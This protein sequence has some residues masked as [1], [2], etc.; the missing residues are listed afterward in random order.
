MRNVL[1]I[2]AAVALFGFISSSYAEEQP[3]T[4]SARVAI[5]A[6]YEVFEDAYYRGDAETIA[7][8]YTE[9]AELLVPGAPAVKG[10]QAIAQ[11]WKK[12]IGAGGNRLDIRTIEVQEAG[13]WAYEVGR[14][15]AKAPEGKVLSVGKY[16]VIWKRQDGGEWKTY[17]DIFN[18][19]VQP[20]S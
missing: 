2:I 10:R 5:A 9:D 18:L 19:D 8:A 11:A 12:I 1:V 4:T 15:T 14:F 17:R 16:I 3:G 20:R 7:Q 6:A 13:D